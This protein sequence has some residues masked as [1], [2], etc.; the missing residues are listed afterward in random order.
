MVKEAVQKGF[1]KSPT[2]NRQYPKIQIKTINDL[3]KDNRLD[4]PSIHISYKKAQPSDKA[5]QIKLGV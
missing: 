4:T 5:E 1:Y 3:L 2:G